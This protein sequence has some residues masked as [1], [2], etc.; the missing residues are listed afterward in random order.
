MADDLRLG[1]LGE[2]R[3]RSRRSFAGISSS[4][5]RS[6]TSSG[7]RVPARRP[8]T[9]RSKIVVAVPFAAE[10]GFRR[11]WAARGYAPSRSDLRGWR[12]LTTMSPKSAISPGFGDRPREGVGETI[13]VL[14]RAPLGDRNEEAVLVLGV[15]PT[16]PIPR[17]DPLLAT[18]SSTACTGAS[19]RT[20][21]SRTTGAS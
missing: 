21:N 2:L 18:R 16:Q 4:R 19:T 5:G 3:G 12:F 17:R 15:F 11:W 10:S 7:G 8:A 9:E 1:D 20:A 14:L 13:D 6:G